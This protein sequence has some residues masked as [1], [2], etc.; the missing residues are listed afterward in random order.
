MSNN[1]IEVSPQI[2][3]AATGA[4]S[5]VAIPYQNGGCVITAHVYGTFGGT[6]VKLQVSP[7]G[8]NWGDAPGTAVTAAGAISAVVAC[9]F[10]RIFATGGA[11]I[12]L[13]A[14]IAY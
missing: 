12:S 2:A 11:G 13:N 7:D 10:A 4:S 5:A 6:S 8:T 9:R 14:K 3:L 1:K